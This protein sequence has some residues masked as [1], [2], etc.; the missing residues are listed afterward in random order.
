MAMAV[1]TA[2][3]CIS[4]SM[5]ALLTMTRLPKGG[6]VAAADVGAPDEVLAAA[7]AALAAMRELLTALDPSPSAVAPNATRPVETSAALASA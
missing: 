6:V 1:S 7:R 5:L 3:F 2:S 4:G